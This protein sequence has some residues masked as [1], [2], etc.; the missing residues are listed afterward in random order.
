MEASHWLFFI[1]LDDYL[2]SVVAGTS[3]MNTAHEPGQAKMDGTA[4][5]LNVRIDFF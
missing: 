2:Y 3:R 4:C 5:S 1:A